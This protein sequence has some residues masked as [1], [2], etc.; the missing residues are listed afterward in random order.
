VA[1]AIAGAISNALDI[2]TA[3]VGGAVVLTHARRTATGN[4]QFTNKVL[5]DTF[6]V[7][8]MSGGQGGLCLIGNPCSEG[9]ECASSHCNPTSH[10]C[11]P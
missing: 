8:G 11:E 10:L 7:D 3:V 2:H 5:P 6:V 1:T 4:V 9:I